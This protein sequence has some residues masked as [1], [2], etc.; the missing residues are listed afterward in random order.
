MGTVA[1]GFSRRAYLP[2]RVSEIFSANSRQPF[3]QSERATE[4][5]TQGTELAA[6]D[7]ASWYTLGVVHYAAGRWDAARVALEKSLKIKPEGSVSRLFLLAMTQWHLGDHPAAQRSYQQAVDW[8]QKDGP[9][10]KELLN[11]LAPKPRSYWGSSTPRPLLRL[12]RMSPQ[13]RKYLDSVMHSRI[14]FPWLARRSASCFD[15]GC[16]VSLYVPLPIPCE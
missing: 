10:N 4:L 11:T 8:M 3:A 13:S 2:P 15:M 12:A 14:P 1:G 9:D 6:D 16:R 5:A 7:V